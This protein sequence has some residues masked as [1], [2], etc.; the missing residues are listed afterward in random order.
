MYLGMNSKINFLSTPNNNIHLFSCDSDYFNKWG[1]HTLITS[2]NVGFSVHFHVINPIE[3]DFN[4]YNNIKTDYPDISMS[5]QNLD[6]GQW[7]PLKKRSYLFCARYLVAKE[8]MENQ[9]IESMLI[10]DADLIFKKKFTLDEIELGILYNSSQPTL[11]SR[12]GGNLFFIRNSMKHFLDDFRDEFFNRFN[13]DLDYDKLQN[14]TKL[15]RAE[16]IGLDQV[17][18]AY[19]IEQNKYKFTNL[20]DLNL[21]SKDFTDETPIWSLTGGG[22]KNPNFD[23]I[24]ETHFY[25]AK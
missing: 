24:L 5:Y 20:I 4:Y 18:L 7:H 25:T 8:I 15:V 19:L 1:K 23:K 6:M 9:S 3:E 12:G 13:Q 2:A 22:K 10:T 21:K 11:W 14:E 17:C 16:K